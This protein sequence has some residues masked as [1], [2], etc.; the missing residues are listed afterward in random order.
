MKFWDWEEVTENLE[1]TMLKEID[2]EELIFKDQFALDDF[3]YHIEYIYSISLRFRFRNHL[4]GE[5]VIEWNEPNRSSCPFIMKFSRYSEY[6]PIEFAY[7]N[8]RHN[9][10]IWKDRKLIV[11]K[12]DVSTSK[13]RRK[14]KIMVGR[15]TLD[16]IPQEVYERYCELSKKDVNQKAIIN[17][18]IRIVRSKNL[19]QNK[20]DSSLFRTLRKVVA[21]GRN[22]HDSNL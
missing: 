4:D 16:K 9:H 22:N 18:S 17:D 10:T 15:K 20:S 5:Y 8:F 19:L 6:G 3:K 13:K 11:P 14:E 2:M 1:K 12:N 7:C 21:L